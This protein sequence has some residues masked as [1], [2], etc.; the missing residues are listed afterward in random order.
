[1]FNFKPV[2]TSKVDYNYETRCVCF[3]L[4]IK[5]SLCLVHRKISIIINIA[6]I[7][8][9]IIIIFILIII[10]WYVLAEDKFLSE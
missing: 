9:Y 6:I 10:F 1:M 8:F 3:A 4:E 7:I 2:F 5:I